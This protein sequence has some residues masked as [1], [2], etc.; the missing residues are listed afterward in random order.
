MYM[1][2]CLFLHKIKL[3]A[4]LLHSAIFPLKPVELEGLG[5]YQN[6]AIWITLISCLTTCGTLASECT[7]TYLQTPLNAVTK[8][9]V[10][11]IRYLFWDPLQR[12]NHKILTILNTFGSLILQQ[13]ETIF[14]TSHKFH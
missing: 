8:A 4:A 10:G 12:Q 6:P 13:N 1:R 7:K 3:P 9:E 14:L 5:S 2:F 11:E